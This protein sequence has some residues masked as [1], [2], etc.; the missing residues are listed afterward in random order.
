[1]RLTDSIKIQSE[2]NSEGASKAWDTRGRNEEEKQQPIHPS[3]E[4]REH[5]RHRSYGGVL[6]NDHGQVLLREPTNHFGGVHWTFAKGGMNHS[7]EH[8]VDVAT[9]EVRE[10]TGHEGKIVGPIKGTFH[11]S[12]GVNNYYLMRSTGH[13]PENMDRETQN[14]KWVSYGEARNMIKQSPN[15]KARSRDLAVLDEAFLTHIKALKK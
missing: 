14:T 13:N 6:I 15:W 9:R 11:G 2:G 1:M 12:T 7:M 5:W 8:P 4:S 10:E 3:W